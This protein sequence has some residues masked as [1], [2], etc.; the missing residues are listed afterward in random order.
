VDTSTEV[1]LKL[2]LRCHE[3]K[4]DLEIEQEYWRENE[5]QIKPC[6]DCL[7]SAEERAHQEGYDKGYEK[8]QGDAEYEHTKPEER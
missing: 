5:I 3:C 8:G 1:T 7:K 4:A 6:P 2:K